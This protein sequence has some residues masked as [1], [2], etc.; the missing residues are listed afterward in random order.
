MKAKLFTAAPKKKP[1]KAVKSPRVERTRNNGTWTEAEFFGRLRAMLRG[2][3]R[4]WKPINEK[5][6][7]VKVGTGRNA[8]YYCENCK[9]LHDKIEINHKIPVG[10]L[11]SYSDLA[12]FCERLFS[13]NLSDFDAFCVKCHLEITKN[14]RSNLSFAN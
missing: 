3:T 1:K 14:Q 5:R 4:Y 11:R 10:T 9:T 13:E 12:G 2:M 7:S 8:K 6:K